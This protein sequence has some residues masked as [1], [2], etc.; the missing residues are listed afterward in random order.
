MLKIRTAWGADRVALA[1]RRLVVAIFAVFA[2]YATKAMVV[3]SAMWVPPGGDTD[4]ANDFTAV[5]NKFADVVVATK[6]TATADVIFVANNFT[7]V[8]C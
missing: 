5:Y 7:P 6:Q 1:L 8:S 3:V 4:N 2:V